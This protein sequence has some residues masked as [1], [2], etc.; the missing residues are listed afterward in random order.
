MKGVPVPVYDVFQ[1]PPISSNFAQPL[2][3]NG[4]TFQMG[5]M[6]SLINSM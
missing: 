5:T 4:T 3:K 1:F 6:N 2:K